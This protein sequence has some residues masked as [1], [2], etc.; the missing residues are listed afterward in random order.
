METS[1]SEATIKRPAPAEEALAAPAP[2]RPT[3]PLRLIWRA[4]W[5]QDSAFAEVRDSKNPL[6]RGLIIALIL[7][8]VAGVAGTLGLG[9]DRLTS[10]S[11]NEV[12][13]TVL[14]GIR[15]MPWYQDQV[16][17]PNG[18]QFQKQFRQGYDLWWKFLPGVLGF[19]TLSNAA[20]TLCIT[21]IAGVIRWAIV[22]ALT[23]L[24]ARMVGGKGG[25]GPTMGVMALAFAPQMFTIAA[26]LPGFQAGNLTGLWS[27][28]LAYWAIRSVHGLSWQRNLLAV[29]LPRIVIIVLAFVL[30]AIG[31]AIAVSVMSTR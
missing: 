14:E 19:P 17:A 18:D 31:A 21:P 28:A 9:L 30:G 3:S 27:L 13:T 11:L 5:F 22:G 6:V 15:K 1:A 16:S 2:A 26:I 4:L 8:A 25:F 7:S 29:L 12:Q 23:Y 20:A 10:P 24:A